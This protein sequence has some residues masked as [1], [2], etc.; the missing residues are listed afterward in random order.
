MCKPILLKT[1]LS[2]EYLV[3]TYGLDILTWHGVYIFELN[4]QTFVSVVLHK[5]VKNIKENIYYIDW[6]N[7]WMLVKVRGGIQYRDTPV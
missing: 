3:A 2:F 4:N 5:T 6:E 7:Y 1:M